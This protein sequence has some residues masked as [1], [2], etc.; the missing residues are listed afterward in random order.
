[1]RIKGA[2]EPGVSSELRSGSI[3]YTVPGSASRGHASIKIVAPGLS[4]NAYARSRP[5][6]PK[7]TTFTPSGNVRPDKRCATST[8]NPS[9]PKN[10]FPMPATKTFGADSCRHL[11]RVIRT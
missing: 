10:M 7:S 4:I 2:S 9:S 3:T 6:I 5:R 1:M 8:P 11:R